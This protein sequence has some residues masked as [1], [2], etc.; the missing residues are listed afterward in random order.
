MTRLEFINLNKDSKTSIEYGKVH[1]ILKSLYIYYKDLFCCE[2]VLMVT[3]V[4]NAAQYV[5]IVPSN[6]FHEAIEMYLE[7][8]KNEELRQYTTETINFNSKL[9]KDLI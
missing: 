8:D 3:D 4:F 2:P 5:K 7:G 1:P 6:E 9:L